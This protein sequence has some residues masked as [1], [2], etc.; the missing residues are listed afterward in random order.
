[1]EVRINLNESV[2]FKLSE[3]GK[4]VYRHRYDGYG[5]EYDSIREPKLDDEG[6][7]SMQ[8][9]M[10]MQTFGEHM[11]LGMPEVVQ[12][13]EIIYE[14]SEPVTPKPIMTE[15]VREAL[16]RLTMCA[17]EEC[18]FCKHVSDCGFDKQVEMATENMHI[19]LDAFDTAPTDSED[20]I[21]RADTI[22]AMCRECKMTKSW[23]WCEKDCTEVAIV[24]GMPPV[25]QKQITGKLESNEIAT[26][27]G[28]ESTMGQ[29]K[30]KLESEQM[31]EYIPKDEVLD[32]IKSMPMDLVDEYVYEL[33]GIWIDEEEVDYCNNCPYISWDEDCISREYIL[34]H[35]YMRDGFM[36]VS[37]DTIKRSP[38]VIQTEKTGEWIVYPLKDEGRVE[39][40]CPECGYA[41]IRA[42]DLRPHF[43]E[44]CGAIMMGGDTEWMMTD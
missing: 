27:E 14:E 3:R 10:F 9:W 40:E 31:R 21:S 26:S 1:M 24:K 39:L 2:K 22:N 11:I 8:L 30:S 37:V 12:P 41:L 4:E 38:S 23:G 29:P 33:D 19:I 16:M 7:V 36:S 15:E 17:R 35:A 44:N 20:C 34:E 28:D 13:L 42:A 6:Y 43:C 5:F 32:I 25:N 18:S